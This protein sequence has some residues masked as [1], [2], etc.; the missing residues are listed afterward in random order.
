MSECCITCGQ[1]VSA[2]NK[3]RMLVEQWKR[4]FRENNVWFSPDDR[5]LPETAAELLGV[6]TKT[7]SNWRCQDKGPKTYR[8]TARLS[9]ELIRIATYLVE[10]N[11]S[12]EN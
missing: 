2:E 10:Q 7:L 4:S 1:I 11:E 3:A 9:Y 12:Y 6:C 5:V 8:G